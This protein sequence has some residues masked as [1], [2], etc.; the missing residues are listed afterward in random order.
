MSPKKVHGD[1]LVV[2]AGSFGTAIAHM[3]ASQRKNIFLW[4]RS[5][6]QAKE[7]NQQH[8]NAKFYPVHRLSKRISATTDLG[9]AVREVPVVIMAIPSNAFRDVARQVGNDWQGDQI[10]LHVTKG[11]EPKTYKRMSEILREETC[12]IKIGP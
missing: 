12:A 5:E 11:I 9:S 2:G 1:A 7:I 10:L 3:L 6:D 8:R 4:T